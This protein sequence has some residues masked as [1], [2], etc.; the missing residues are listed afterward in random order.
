MP[1]KKEITEQKKQ[2]LD[3]NPNPYI[4]RGF[5]DEQE[6]D[7]I[8]PRAKMLQGL[9]PELNDDNLA[10]LNLK[11][12]MLLNSLTYEV[13]PEFFI[14]IFKFNSKVLWI[15]R[16]VG[17]G[18]ACR[19]L[20]GLSGTVADNTKFGRYNKE[21]KEFYDI[22]KV[23]NGQV[24]QCKD[25]QWSKWDGDVPPVCTASMNFLSLYDGCEFP[26]VN[27]FVNTSFKSGKKLYSLCKMRPGDM[28]AFKYRIKP[29]RKTNEK[30]TFFVAEI[31]PG[32][33]SNEVEYKFAEQLYSMF[34]GK[35]I[36]FHEEEEISGDPDSIENSVTDEM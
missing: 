14:P 19:A 34:K 32:G 24:I 13:L 20:D 15:P 25:C 6:G 18:M 4:R 29:T 33:R 12:G 28:F 36:K 1:D 7:L 31:Y 3:A 8:M 35:D 21:K 17:G 27:S 22:Q 16:E 23:E 11:P 10:D 5:E 26:L 9:S 2:E 30:G